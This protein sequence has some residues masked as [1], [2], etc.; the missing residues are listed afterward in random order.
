MMAGLLVCGRDAV[1]G[2]RFDT[3]SLCAHDAKQAATYNVAMVELEVAARLPRCKP[4]PPS[5]PV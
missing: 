1:S 3:W 4:P 5:G 2:G